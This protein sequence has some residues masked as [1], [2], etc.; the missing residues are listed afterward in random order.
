MCW[1][2]ANI[3]EGEWFDSDTEVSNEGIIEN[4]EDVSP[5][6]DEDDDVNNNEEK[7]SEKL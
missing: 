2:N 1:R 4:I 5:S 7:D 3:S 6:E